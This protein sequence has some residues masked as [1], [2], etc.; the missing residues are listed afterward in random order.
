MRTTG[1]QATR[2]VHD[3]GVGVLSA[4][5]ALPAWLGLSAF[6]TTA[7]ALG[8]SLGGIPFSLPYMLMLAVPCAA[9]WV[10][11]A[12]IIWRFAGAAPPAPIGSRRALALHAAVSFAFSLAW[13]GAF[14]L[15]LFAVHSTPVRPDLDLSQALRSS[16]YYFLLPNA[17]FYWVALVARLAFDFSG[18]LQLEETKRARLEEQL[19]RSRLDVLRMQMNPHFLFNTL[20]SI[21]GL[22]RTKDDRR[23]LDVIVRLGNLLRGSLEDGG[24]TF[25]PVESELRQL[26]GFIG[27]ERCRFGERLDIEVD[28]EPGVEEAPIPRWLLQPLVENA[29]RHGIEASSQ[30]GRVRVRIQRGSE[31]RLIVE[32]EDDGIGMPE[33]PTEGIGLGNT[34]RLLDELFGNDWTLE[35]NRLE[36]GTLVRLEL[37]AEERL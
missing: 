11:A 29:I 8:D 20:N 2:E 21:G 30:A 17:L 36:P 18:R 37:P 28:V 9:L 12:P 3:R 10:A 19:V 34:R 15:V 1:S 32:V 13:V 5:R 26:D 14:G 27:I 4:R 24:D 31:K 33:T 16:A 23:A 7:F 25:A 6:L 35:I 22:I